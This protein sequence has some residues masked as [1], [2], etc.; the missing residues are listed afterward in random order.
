MDRFSGKIWTRVKWTQNF[1]LTFLSHHHLIFLSL[2]RSSLDLVFT[3]FFIQ[4]YVLTTFF[5][6]SPR[7]SL[8]LWSIYV[9]GLHRVVSP[10]M[11]IPLPSPLRFCIFF[12]DCWNE[13]KWISNND[14]SQ[15]SRMSR[16]SVCL[17]IRYW[18]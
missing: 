13:D 8:S 4:W 16:F 12:F 17:I 1:E 10:D 15:Y 11:P 3:F 2:L 6:C 14:E 18:I 5:V 7:S 9:W